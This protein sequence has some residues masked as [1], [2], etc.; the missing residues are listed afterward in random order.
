MLIKMKDYSLFTDKDLLKAIQS[1][2][3]GAFNE[4]YERYVEE[5]LSFVDGKIQDLDESKDVIQEIFVYL[6]AER[7][8]FVEVNSISHYLYR[9][10]VNKSRNIFRR[11]K[12]NQNY[13]DSLAYFLVNTSTIQEDDYNERQQEQE[14]SKAIGS[15]PEKMRAIFELRYYEGLS[16]EQVAQRLSI[17]VHTVATQMK[18]ALKSIRN[19]LNIIGFLAFLINL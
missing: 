15:L 9:V 7:H 18:R 11:Q 2:D 8:N 4:L 6:W 10:A 5:L 14:L 12:I 16:N 17:S 13:I 19:Q 1:N 3:R